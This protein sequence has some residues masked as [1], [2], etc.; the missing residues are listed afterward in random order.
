MSREQD[1]R[2]G[3][4]SRAQMEQRL[5]RPQRELMS[6]QE[7][8]EEGSKQQSQLHGLLLLRSSEAVTV[9][10]SSELSS[11]RVRILANEDRNLLDS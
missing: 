6:S 11:S 2:E 5:Q 8:L 1:K 9:Y 7:L 10:S 4:S 3:T